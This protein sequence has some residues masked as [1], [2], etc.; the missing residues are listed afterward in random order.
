M[1]TTS[2]Q[3][4]RMAMTSSAQAMM[5]LLVDD[6][7][8]IG[9]A[10]RRVLAGEPG[11]DFHYCPD[12]HKAIAIAK[13]IRPTV[14]LQDLVMPGVNG[15]DLVRE[16]R[17]D[18]DTRDIPVI[19]LSTKEE[20]L[21]KS[22]AFG[23]GA[24]DYLVK[25]PDRLELIARVRYHSRA[26]LNQLER[27]EAYTA[28]RESQQN[29]LH[30][31]LELQ[32]LTKIDGLT[33]L[34]NRRYFDEYMA[35][36]WGRAQ[37]LA[38]PLAVMMIDVDEFKRYNDT[39]GHLAGD[40]VLRSVAQVIQHHAQ[41]ASGLASRFGGE[42]FAVVLSDV[43]SHNLQEI[44]EQ[45][46]QGVKVLDLPHRA[47]RA[48]GNVTVSIGAA[49]TVPSKIQH[50]TELIEVADKALY[51]SKARGRNRSTLVESS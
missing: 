46:C 23:A 17:Q 37:R 51:Q 7:V 21:I 34:S 38:L 24:N 30:A 33:G 43:L 19:V 2:P 29:L 15:L 48:S 1:N 27:D 26:Y 14:I 9:E 28:L 49:R 11:L 36:E 45:L 12:P 8:M 18:R 4:A 10:L 6:Q 3:P 20:P 31:N 32:R 42:E 35:A 39:Y 44:G 50:Y 22:E 41:R 25:L 13:Q 16:Y 47:S 40:D 5:V